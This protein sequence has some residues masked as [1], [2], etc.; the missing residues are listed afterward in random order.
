MCFWVV[1]LVGQ[2]L[3]R[4]CRAQ[5]QPEYSAGIEAYRELHL[6]NGLRAVVAVDR[7]APQVA[8][9]LQYGVGDALDPPDQ[10]GLARLVG[11]L[12]PEASTS[13]VSARERG[14]LYQAAGFKYEAPKVQVG[15]DT[16][17]LDL[18]VPSEALELALWVEADRMGFAADGLTERRIREATPDAVKSLTAGLDPAFPAALWT[19]RPEHPYAGLVGA[20]NLSGAN[21]TVVARRLRRFYNPA[22][23]IVVL[24]GDVALPDAERALEHS[25]GLLAA[26]PVA[27][28]KTTAAAT[29]PPREIRIEAPL[30]A[31]VVASGW[32]T[33]PFLSADDLGLDIVA[34]LLGR[35]L[36]AQGLCDKVAASQRSRFLASVFSVTCTGPKGD[37]AA[38]FQRA[39][40][41]QLAE[42]ADGKVSA[43]E[44][45]GTALTWQ[46]IASE[47]LD[48]LRG[49]ATWIATAV[50]LGH[51]PS[52]IVERLKAYA[53]FDAK[54]LSDVVR[55]NLLGAP[56]ALL[57]VLPAPS[58]PKEGRA[59]SGVSKP[60][61]SPEVE[62]PALPVV[63][64]RAWPRPPAAGPVRRY[65][66]PASVSETLPSGDRL[67]FVPREG[68][69]LA[70][71]LLLVLWRAQSVDPAAA[72]VLETLLVHDRS[73]GESLEQTLRGL[74]ARVETGVDR[75]SLGITITAPPSRLPLALRALAA[76]LWK[77]HFSPA[78]FSDAVRQTSLTWAQSQPDLRWIAL[79]LSSPQ[80]RYRHLQRDARER[81]LGALKLS[82]IEK[83][84]SR[85][86]AQP[87]NVNLVG[88][89]DADTARGFAKTLTQGPSGRR[90]SAPTVAKVVFSPGVYVVDGGSADSVDGCVLWPLP[91]WG[92]RMHTPANLMPWFFG[93]DV[94]DGLSAR[95]SENGASGPRWSSNT[96]LT[97]DGD[98]LHY[99]FTAPLDQV[100]PIL[101]SLKAHTTHLAEGQFH[102]DDLLRARQAEHQYQI[103]Q[104]LSSQQ[105]LWSLYRASIHGKEVS[106][107]SDIPRLLSKLDGDALSTFLKGLRFDRTIIGLQGPASSLTTELAKIELKPSVVRLAGPP[108]SNAVRSGQ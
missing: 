92:T 19:W 14:H 26:A 97:A 91:T 6:S 43:S 12:L 104:S 34:D 17:T 45:E 60:R 52:F 27:A 9:H 46:R 89:F 103:R 24:V 90:L 8:L 44:L 68:L 105:W 80:S 38:P 10:R 53:A 94:Q 83:L 54:T 98:F 76:A 106:D 71:V 30:A 42:L 39:T 82:D 28:L 2:L 50:R 102:W 40:E 95:L 69:P 3:A 107:A 21:A 29:A 35:R 78:S 74:G 100:A 37:S 101:K 108:A 79:G 64:P 58:A 55:R 31:R 59:L 70:Q 48:D 84:W 18:D 15:T 57:D 5:A 72:E 49:R 61:Y 16:T 86:R 77:D 23:A 85:S 56:A 25:F 62:P 36:S 11:A 51:E 67:L 75:G 33:P 22:T 7:R 81:A 96:L 87:L 4:P 66:P 88:P 99:C 65:Q 93:N 32:L 13:H 47:R 63:K 1:A 73:N 20:A 41:A